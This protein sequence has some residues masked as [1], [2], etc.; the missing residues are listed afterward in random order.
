MSETVKS[1]SE[2]FKDY[3]KEHNDWLEAKKLVEITYA[4]QSETVKKISEANGGNK[5]IKRRTEKGIQTLTIVKRGE[6]WFFRGGNSDD[7]QVVE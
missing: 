7:S 4:K 1:L 3:D 6:S 5:T 2:L